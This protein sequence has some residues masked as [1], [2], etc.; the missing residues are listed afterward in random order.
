MNVSGPDFQVTLSHKLHT[1][2]MHEL[3][4]DQTPRSGKHCEGLIKPVNSCSGKNG[5]RGLPSRK[6]T[7]ENCRGGKGPGQI[8]NALFCLVSYFSQDD[9][10]AGVWKE[11]PP[12]L[13]TWSGS[14]PHVVTWL[15]RRGT[16]PGRPRGLPSAFGL[17][18]YF[19]SLYI[20]QH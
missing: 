9:L 20:V 17:D 6:A 18:D 14:D 16:M 12:R 5:S 2:K 15:Q 7:N 1:L 19:P 8:W 10:Q 11:C 4:N 13:A 3:E